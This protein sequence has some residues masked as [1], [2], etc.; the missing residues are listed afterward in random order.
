MAQLLPYV[1]F[2][3]KAK[4]AFGFYKSVLGGE[5]T[6]TKVGDSPM[7]Q[8]M[9]DKMDYIFHAQ[10]K[11][12]NMILLGSDMAGEE[13]LKQG[14]RVVLTLEC[15]NKEEAEKY[16]GNLSEGGNIGHAL[17]DQEFGT[18]GDFQDKYGIDWFVV[19]MKAR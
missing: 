6:V 17:A 18:I 12:E 15:A 8:H 13:G 14:N 10:L 5:L 7:A 9:S 11:S 3:G 1:R 4:E 16:F 2:N 19:A